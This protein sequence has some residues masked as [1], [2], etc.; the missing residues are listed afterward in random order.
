LFRD[1][2]IDVCYLPV[3]EPDLE[4]PERTRQEVR[5][6]LATSAHSVVILQ[7]SRLERW[8]GHSVHIEALAGL[9][10]LPN[11]V[12]WIAGGPQKAG[13]SELLGEL[14]SSIERA[15]IADRVRFLGQRTDV[16]R[17]MCASDT[18]CQPNTSPEPF[19]IVF[20]EAL[21]AGLPVVTSA[22]GGAMEIVN[23]SC[24]VLCPPCN[25]DAV[26]TALRGLIADPQWRRSLGKGGPARARELCEP[27]R[28]MTELAK[29]IASELKVRV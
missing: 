8:K 16:Q 14:K 11:W 26:A 17:L 10:D 25:P 29:A 4:M 20:I 19:G 12:A 6:S 28:Q 23:D 5:E 2:S 13:E 21:Y 15:G 24:G 27:H 1:A 18:Y 7:A 3:A 22:L 9:R